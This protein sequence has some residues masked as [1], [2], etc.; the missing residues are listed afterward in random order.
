MFGDED[1]PFVIKLVLGVLIGLLILVLCLAILALPTTVYDQMYIYPIAAQKANE[2]CESLGFDFY[3]SFS[4]VGL[5][6]KNPI[7][8]KCKYVEQYRQIDINQPLVQVNS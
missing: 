5:F 8:I 1:M 2:Y 7:A 4:R 3:E 6:S